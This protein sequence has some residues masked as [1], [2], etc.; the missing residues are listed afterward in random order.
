MEKISR[1]GNT[2]KHAAKTLIWI[3]TSSL[4]IITRENALQRKVSRLETMAWGHCSALKDSS[5]DLQPALFPEGLRF[6]VTYQ[7]LD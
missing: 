6:V 4:Q 2:K 7:N 1:K 3:T 5:V